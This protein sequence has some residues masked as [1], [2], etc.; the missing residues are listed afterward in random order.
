MG[1]FKQELLNV[2]GFVFD[3]DGVFTDGKILI[4]ENGKQIRAMNVKDGYA[5]NF[6][7]KKNYP[8]GIITGGTCESIKHRFNSLGVYDV[9]IA[10]HNKMVDFH[11]FLHKYHLEPQD[12]LYMG[13]DLPDY[14]VM[15]TCGLPT[16]PADAS[17]EI[18]EIS[19]H[20]SHQKGGNG[21]IRD[22]IEQVLKAQGKW[23]DQ[24]AFVW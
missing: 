1:K 2:K 20:I 9:Y 13:D 7:R 8:I 3:V 24:D 21:C 23:L 15:K 22:V 19:H 6:A 4:T 18:K 10:S 5:V 11:D 17:A 12:I 14:N 16:C